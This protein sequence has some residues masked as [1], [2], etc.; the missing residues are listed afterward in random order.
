MEKRGCTGIHCNKKAAGINFDIDPGCLNMYIR[1][2]R[3]NRDCTNY[4]PLIFSYQ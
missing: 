1:C 2:L 3:T 4:L